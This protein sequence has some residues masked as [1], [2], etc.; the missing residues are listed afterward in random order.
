M[1]LAIITTPYNTTNPLAKRE[2]ISQIKRDFKTNLLRL[3]CTDH[4][5][6]SFLFY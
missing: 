1:N 3:F 5:S 4:F 2:P 6:F